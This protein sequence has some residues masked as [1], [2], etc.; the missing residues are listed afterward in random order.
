M[1]STIVYG[2]SSDCSITQTQTVF[3]G[4]PPERQG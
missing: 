1:A 2:H 4:D 3:T